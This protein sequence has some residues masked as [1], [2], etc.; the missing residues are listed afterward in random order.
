L[1]N[2]NVDVRGTAPGI[3]VTTVVEDAVQ[4]EVGS[5]EMGVRRV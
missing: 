5:G 4:D 2:E 3:L 1:V